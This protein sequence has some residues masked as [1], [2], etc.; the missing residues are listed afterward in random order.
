MRK[1]S[2]IILSLI[3][4]AFLPHRVLADSPHG[5]GFNLSCDL[6]HNSTNW[7]L[8][9]SIYAFNHSTTAF[10]LTGQHQAVNCRSCHPTLVFSEA[11]TAC[12]ECHTDM[13]NQTV[14]PDC[15]RCHTSKSWIVENITEL[16][17]RSR[18]PLLGAHRTTDCSNC[19]KSA[20]LLRFEPLGVLCYDCHQ[21]NYNA[22]TQPNHVQGNFSKDCIQCHSINGS[23]WTSSNVDHSFFPLTKGH[24]N[25]N[26]S[27]CHTNGSFTNISNQ[28][29]S[30]HVSNYNTSANPNH[31]SANI[32][33]TCA[34]CHTTDFGWKPATFT[35]HNTYYALT[36]AH[37]TTNC[38]QC[39][40]GNYAVTA[41]TCVGCHQANYD[42]SQNPNH[43]VA[44]I[45][46]SCAD[47]HTTTPGWKPASF[48]IHN[49]YWQL[50]GAHA[51][52]TCN[53]C[54][55]GVYTNTP[56]T[57]VGCHLTA[58]NQTTNPPHASSQFGTDCQSC[59]STSAWVPATFDHDSKYF[60]IYS[61]KHQGTWTLCTD[62]H[63]TASNY[64][65]FSCIDCH[66][67]NNQSSVNNQHQ[68]VGGYSYTSLACYSCHPTG[69]VSGSFDHNN[70][71]FPL[72]GAHT[73]VLCSA[74]HVNGFSGT[75][76]LCSSCHTNAYNQTN[77]PNHISAGIPNTCATCH[78][79]NPGWQPATFPTH[80]NYYALTGA[81]ASITNCDQCHNGNYTNTTPN[82]CVGCHQA[83]YN[84]TTNPN[85]TTLGISTDCSSC[86]TTNPGWTPALFTVHNNYWP[87]TG[88]H[89]SITNCNL[90][91]NGNY[92]TAPTNCVDCHLNDYNQ[93]TNPPHASAQFPTD[94]QSCHTT[95][96]WSP[97][98]F[99]H[100]GQYFPIYSGHHAGKWTLCAD[101]HT[102]ASN[103]QVF[104]CI[105]C[106]A[107]S[108]Q[109]QVNNEHQGVSGYSYNSI[110]CYNCHPTGGGGSKILNRQKIDRN[111]QK[112]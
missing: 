6:C 83:N 104:S 101:C 69:S 98:T 82:T 74:C 26:C 78:T 53:Q 63:T 13:H 46:T 93:T 23:T 39:H 103:Y 42:N 109:S 45:P 33:T 71:G 37:I 106:H 87:L 52:T 55:N 5:I 47:C 88:A 40:N 1:L 24:G 67:H 111:I 15:G 4:V 27:R 35:I 84:Q 110:A 3:A 100:D 9:K 97:S 12:N 56:N 54:H 7:T 59:H 14:G 70:T 64:A 21:A 107:H 75:S 112:N 89:A 92:N 48:A 90:C 32:P 68:G 50:T 58:Y 61:G 73:T 8:D 38:D 72:T 11:K 36:G 25:L 91:H 10:P 94:C 86:H 102:N 65:I 22:A 62:C 108:N 16:H 28:C 77:N 99:N 60:P 80:N 18:F 20:S 44:N 31:K 57:C 43:K 81:H 49:T 79:T 41:N 30:C 17:Q 96:A 29:V 85:H 95:I 105:D 66:A 76:T 2:L 51:T 19:H 34:D